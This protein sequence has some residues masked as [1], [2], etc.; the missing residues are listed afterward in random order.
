MWKVLSDTTGTALFLE[1][2]FG[3]YL[4]NSQLCGLDNI[5]HDANNSVFILILALS[6]G[7]AGECGP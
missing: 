2:I 3:I 5:L 6:S 7:S 1:F 4:W